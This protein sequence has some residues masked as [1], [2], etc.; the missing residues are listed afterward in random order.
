MR[1]LDIEHTIA[2]YPDAVF[3]IGGRHTDVGVVRRVNSKVVKPYSWSRERTVYEAEVSWIGPNGASE[4][5]YRVPL[6]Q[7]IDKRFNNVA[8]YQAAA[9][10]ATERRV[11]AR[12]HRDAVIERLHIAL[13]GYDLDV[14]VSYNGRYSLSL[15]EAQALALAQALEPGS[16]AGFPPAVYEPSKRVFLADQPYPVGTGPVESYSN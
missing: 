14:D 8:E 7:V 9:A 5:T 10:E 15:T 13:L 4:H 6:G 16:D 11:Q 1:K 3:N 12:E 2:E